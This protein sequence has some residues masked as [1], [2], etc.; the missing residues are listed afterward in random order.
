M[1]YEVITSEAGKKRNV[2]A[3]FHLKLNTGMNRLGVRRGENLEAFLG[4]LDQTE[5]V[6]F[7]GIFSHFAVSDVDPV[8]TKEQYME[9]IQAMRQIETHEYA[10]KTHISNSAAIATYDSFDFV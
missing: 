1:L 2:R 5:N 7:S 10:P 6:Y 3:K 8:F 4:A 9:F